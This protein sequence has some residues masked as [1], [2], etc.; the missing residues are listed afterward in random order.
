MER[1]HVGSAACRVRSVYRGDSACVRGAAG[2][3]GEF[4]AG[5]GTS[6]G[7]PRAACGR[8][9]RNRGAAQQLRH[10][11]DG[12]VEVRVRVPHPCPKGC[13]RGERLQLNAHKSGD[14]TEYQA[15]YECYLPQL[16]VPQPALKARAAGAPPRRNCGTMWTGWQSD[17]SSPANPC[18]ANCE[19]GEL[20]AVNRS[21]SNGKLVYDM[22]Y[23]C[24]G[25]NREIKKG[26][27]AAFKPQV[28]TTAAIHLTGTRRAP[29]VPAIVTTGSIQL[30]GTRRP[31][32][33]P[34]VVTTGSIQLTGTRRPPFVPVVV[35][36]DSIQL[37]GTRRPRI[38]RKFEG[39]VILRPG[40]VQP[41][42]PR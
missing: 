26:P 15:N 4:R 33:V 7:E 1:R 21:L 39:D 2:A 22:N 40:T 28:V 41:L 3:R 16:A 8:A 37:T 17:P 32:F 35:M 31:P 10:L 30:T 42:T 12:M 34:V 6:G 13:E 19:R 27:R 25:K 36:T 20:R 18:P 38:P 23:Q 14:T 9:F 11:L 24:Y 5:Q 29:F